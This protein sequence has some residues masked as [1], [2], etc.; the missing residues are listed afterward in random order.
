MSEITVGTT[1]IEESLA[2]HGVYASTTRGI[3]MEPL[4]RTHRDVVIIERPK[5]DLKK[6][7]VA[8]Y[9]VKDRYIMHRVIKVKAD[10]YLIRGDNTFYT[11]HVPKDKILGVLVEFNRKGKHHSVKERS[12]VA[13]SRFWNL[14]YPIRFLWNLFIRG[15]KKIYRSLFKRKKKSQS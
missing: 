10:E 1:G 11:E 13:Y 3:S 5:G 6:Y 2:T 15:L 12:F 8:L 4:F 7:D 9:R 14:I